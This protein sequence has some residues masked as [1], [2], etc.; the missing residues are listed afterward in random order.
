MGEI[1][2]AG[3]RRRAKVLKSALKSVRISRP[4]AHNPGASDFP[5][6]TLARGRSRR[7]G[8][9]WRVLGEGNKCVVEGAKSRQIAVRLRRVGGGRTVSEFRHP[10]RNPCARNFRMQLSRAN[11][12]APTRRD[13][14]VSSLDPFPPC[15]P[16][17]I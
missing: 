9:R 15:P 2:G 10:E 16:S 14:F 8:G 11:V 3:F 13:G 12:A 7:N 5:I 6:A 4:A 17:K 1:R